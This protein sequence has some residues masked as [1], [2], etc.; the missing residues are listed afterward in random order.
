MRISMFRAMASYISASQRPI[1]H[2]AIHASLASGLTDSREAPYLSQA[3]PCISV[4]EIVPVY[5]LPDKNA[6]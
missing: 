6:D 3:S 2:Q 1:L 5:S 4:I